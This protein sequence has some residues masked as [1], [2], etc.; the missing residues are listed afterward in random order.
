MEK[1]MMPIEIEYET[2][3]HIYACYSHAFSIFR[4]GKI[5]FFPSTRLTILSRARD[6][7]RVLIRSLCNHPTSELFV[8]SLQF[9]Q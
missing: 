2:V 3:A 4:I 1:N 7:L 8:F 6:F 5:N 9:G